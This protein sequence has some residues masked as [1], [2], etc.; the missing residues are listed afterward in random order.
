LAECDYEIY[1]KELMALI[2]CFE[3]WRLELEGAKHPIKVLTDYRNLEYFMTTKLLNRRQTRWSEYLSCFNFKIMF[4]PGRA[5]AKPD[6]LTRQPGDLP[7][8]N[9]EQ[10]IEM[11]KAV[12]KSQ[13]LSKNLNIPA[14][15]S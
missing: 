6:T 8:P 15:Q 14:T 7:G 13:N 10:I 12:L 11:E 5:G 3:E 2:R 4:R 1:D 9:D